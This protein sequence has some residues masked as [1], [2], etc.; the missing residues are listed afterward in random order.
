MGLV[1]LGEINDA[2]AALTDL[3]NDAVRADVAGDGVEGLGSGLGQCLRPCPGVERTDDRGAVAF[4]LEQ[5][6]DLVKQLGVIAA[7]VLD[8]E[9]SFFGRALAGLLQELHR[10]LESF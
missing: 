5:R 7:L 6:H 1:L 4:V 9:R 3:S 10:Q 8:E 2:H